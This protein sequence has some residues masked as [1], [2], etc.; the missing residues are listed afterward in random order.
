MELAP[1]PEV[2]LDPTARTLRRARLA[3]HHAVQVVAAVGQSLAPPAPDD[4]QQALAIS[5]L[6]RWLGAPV[7]EGR[8]RAGLDPVDVELRLCDAGGVPLAGIGL[9]GRTLGEGLRFLEDAFRRAGRPSTL[10]LPRHPADFPHH[11]L[12][13]GAAF[14][15]G[16]APGRTELAR[17][18]HGT[19]VLLTE[20]LRVRSSPR[21]WPH[22]FD[23]GCSLPLGNLALGLGVSPGDGAE[24]LPYWYA[25]LT[26]WPWP[27][28]EEPPSLRT[29]AWRRAGWK[30]AELPLAALPGDAAGQASTVEA[31]F[32]SALD[33][34]ER[35]GG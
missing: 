34:A 24:G 12:A 2:A 10:V 29:G 16:G 11:P 20:R 3:L 5:G 21:L 35:L 14:P 19:E 9:E 7:A 13:D 27:E 30:G 22:H 33:V 26:P 23:L 15:E 17:L 4:S 32:R 28:G 25:T 18:L 6:R 31:F 8:L 1:W